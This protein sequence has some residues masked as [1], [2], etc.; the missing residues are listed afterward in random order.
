MP[1]SVPIHDPTEASESIDFLLSMS[2]VQ[3]PSDLYRLNPSTCS[4]NGFFSAFLS[5][6]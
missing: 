1:P 2:E 5:D 4:T 3:K 6:Q